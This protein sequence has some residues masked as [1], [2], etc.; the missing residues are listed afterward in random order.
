MRALITGATSGIGKAFALLLSQRGFD[1]ILASRNTA[2]MRKL[3]KLLPTHVDIVTVD[4][5]KEADCYRLYETVKNM[6]IDLVINNAGMGAV[7]QFAEIP[8][9]KELDM[10]N[11][12]VRAV[13][14]L[15]KLFL[16]DFVRRDYGYILNVASSAGFIAGPLMA[17][18]YA[19][20]NYVLRLTQAVAE[21]LRQEG[22]RVRVSALC[23]GPVDTDF[24]RNANAKS[25]VKGISPKKA[26]AAGLKGVFAGK[27]VILPDGGTY[28]TR[29]MQRI[30]PE[31][32]LLPLTYAIQKRKEDEHG[33]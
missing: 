7:G 23:P 21:E 12:N 9:E 8:L 26:A 19:G 30:L 24:N 4:L 25:A 22:S 18:Y 29:L 33:T 32:C 20:K 14:I 28:A 31:K 10:L 6:P 11:L 16:Q 3:Q 1:L 17:S 2:K 27:T 15:T 5:T 13:H